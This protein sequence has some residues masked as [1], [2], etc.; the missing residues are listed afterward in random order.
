[1]EQAG[2]DGDHVHLEVHEEAGDLQRVGQ[3]RLPGGALLTLVGGLGKSIGAVQDVQVSAWL[4]LGNLLQER[5]YLG[6]RAS[7]PD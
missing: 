4:V 7:N 6:H 3:V 1:V 5:L 2:G